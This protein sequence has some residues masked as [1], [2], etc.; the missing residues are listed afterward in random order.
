[1]SRQNMSSTIKFFAPDIFTMA[2]VTMANVFSIARCA[3]FTEGAAS[4]GFDAAPTRT[5]SKLE[6]R[7]RGHD[8]TGFAGKTG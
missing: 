7:L 6:G 5:A 3:S 2:N 8:N 4:I 1:M